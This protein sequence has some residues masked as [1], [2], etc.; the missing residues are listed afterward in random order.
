M[1]LSARLSPFFGSILRERGFEIYRS[2]A[3]HFTTVAPDWI[4]ANVDGTLNYYA[5]IALRNGELSLG[6]SCPY[7]QANGHCKHLWAVVLCASDRSFLPAALQDENLKIAF[8]KPLPESERVQPQGPASPFVLP[9][10]RPAPAPPAVT[11]EPPP[12][13]PENPLL[14]SNAERPDPRGWYNSLRPWRNVI[15]GVGRDVQLRKS[16]W[17]AGREVAYIVDFDAS[18]VRRALV[19]H[20]LTRDPRKSGNGYNMERDLSW[21]QDEISSIP[22]SAHRE[23]ISMLAGAAERRPWHISELISGHH[24]IHAPLSAR[25]VELA[26]RAGSCYGRPNTYSEAEPIQWDDGEPWQFRIRVG[27]AK[28]SRVAAVGELYRGDEKLNLS[29]AALV[30]PGLLFTSTKAARLEHGPSFDWIALLAREEKIDAA[31]SEANELAA[32]LLGHHTRPALEIDPEVG[33][34]RFEPPLI[35]HFIIRPAEARERDEKALRGEVLFQ[36]DAYRF[37]PEDP[38]RG[39]FD[40]SHSLYI[41]RNSDAEKEALAALE[42]ASLGASIKLYEPRRVYKVS[43]SRLTSIASTLIGRGWRVEAEGKA[44]RK[45]VSNSFSI[46]TGIDWF[47]LHA[48]FDFGGA[49]AKLPELL[50]ALRSGQP[51]VPLSDGT[52]GLLSQEWIDRFA[53]LAEF[54]QADE[55]VVKFRRTQAGLLDALLAAEP[56]NVDEGFEHA[57]AQ[58]KQFE[59]IKPLPQPETFN[60]QLR[61]Y[62]QEGLGWMEFLRRF[63][64]GGCLADDM[65]VGKTA[66]V[67]AALESRRVAGDRSGPSLVVLPRSLVFNWKQEAARFTPGLRI[68]D[69]TGVDRDLGAIP[70]ADVVLTTYGI[71]RR[72]ILQLREI[73]F[74]YA[75]LDEAQAIKNSAS[76]SAKAARLL[77]AKHRLALSGT[78]V[79]NHL[80]E[81]AS[82]FEF[83]NPGMMGAGGQA[84][85][86]SG[87]MRNATPESRTML[88]HS[89]RPFILR[90]TKQQV[91]REL[92]PKTE[93]TIYCEMDPPQRK[94]YDE[95]RQFYRRS[96]LGRV[97][98]EGLAKSKIQVLEALLRLRQ[99]AC[100]PGLLDAKRK[101]DTSAKMET[102]IEQA[103]QVVDEGHKALVF[104][105]FT[106][107]LA[108]VKPILDREKIRYEYLDGSTTDR[109]A[110]VERF[111]NDPDCPLFLISLKAGGLGL[112]LTAAEYVY[113]L[114][115]WWNPAVEAQAIDRSHRIGQTQHVFAYRLITKDTVEEKVLALQNT[116][117]DLA[118]AI[119]GEDN[120]LIRD[121]KRE[122]LEMLLG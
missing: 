11:A 55:T 113:L 54:G 58:L 3:V 69:H 39:Y 74:D 70:E 122:D 53:P 85:L 8:G 101:A 78:P 36:Y 61:E 45:P 20:I 63:E 64:F 12:P 66:Q 18:R 50:K 108:I 115:P 82:I 76:E 40:H 32:S 95:L 65:G 93:Q 79:E 4:A 15:E 81:L 6:C 73:A 57:R 80:G 13:T 96:L 94:L 24:E 71:L 35:P 44:F 116:K 68:Y 38:Q 10:S 100:H 16:R 49:T 2:K 33:L 120:S 59:G 17:P 77:K 29:T 114:D 89:L 41:Q 84:Q 103:R 60:G 112:N 7:A 51:I 117:R 5:T 91:A 102:L 97:E 99:A 28:A 23:I 109:Q 118:N 31:R 104:S 42:D 106:S 47:E 27:L 9:A 43:R 25:I 37:Y 75:I 48:D 21:P 88:A 46:T 34:E 22:D 1:S 105:Q 62:Q 86:S 121:L 83:L 56:V 52:F 107:L 90:R 87:F 111:Q 19:L 14:V 30:I 110:H 92:P 26:A 98:K 67:L 119:I 72:D